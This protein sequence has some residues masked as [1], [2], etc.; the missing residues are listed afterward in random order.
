MSEDMEKTKAQLVRELQALRQRVADLESHANMATPMVSEPQ[1]VLGCHAVFEMARDSIFIKDCEQRYVK[2][3]PAMEQLFGVPASE[4]IGKTDTALFG[5]EAGLHICEVDTRVLAGETAEEEHTKLVNGIPYTFHVIKVPIYDADGD[6]VG[7]GGIARDITERRNIEAALREKEA[8]LRRI[9]EGTDA[10][11]L[12]VDSR[13]RI[14]YVNEGAAHL[15]GYSAEEL[16]GKL[17]LRFVHPK[18]R[19]RVSK[20]YLKQMQTGQK[21]APMEYRI[22]TAEDHVRWITIV[23]HPLVTQ[24]QVVGQ[25]GVAMDITARKQI[26]NALAESEACYRALSELVSDSAY[27]VRVAPDGTLEREWA[28]HA[29]SRLTGFTEAERDARGGVLSTFHP[30]DIPVVQEV[31]QNIFATGRPQ[32]AEVR[33]VTKQG[34]IRWMRHYVRPIWDASEQRYTRLIGAM[35]DITEHKQAQIALQQ[36]NQDLALLNAAGQAFSSTLDLDQVLATVLV[37][38]RQLLGV[39]ATSIWLV[40]PETQILT[41]QQATG[42]QSEIVQGW[43][44]KPGKGIAGWVVR[45]GQSLIVRDAQADSRHFQGVCEATGL[46]LHSILCI[47]L[48]IKRKIIGVIQ[49]VD[50]AVNRFDHNELALV[51][52]LAS[53]AAF[54]IENARLYERTQD[55]M[56][57]LQRLN[58][59]LRDALMTIKSLRGLIPICAWCGK[60]I[61]DEAGQWYE[62]E[63]YIESHSEAKFTHGICPECLRAWAHKQNS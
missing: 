54:A 55:D 46:Q 9:I 58:A 16:L 59:E 62:L 11:L 25:T 27:V 33:L 20:A 44:L 42:V 52:S 50:E 23:T 6:I 12:N 45:H 8:R 51:E 26:E 34:D 5:E 24:G 13:G 29:F 56:S 19:D 31:L 22:L 40:D 17:Y 10:L 35:Q 43:Q 57:E 4:L 15:V 30:D 2:V 38:V 61:Q 53:T 37:Q 49:V 39:V 32:A 41:C 18:D 1:E 7:L 63:S 48:R 21:S 60:K 36:R 14:T 47:P 28:S 3:N